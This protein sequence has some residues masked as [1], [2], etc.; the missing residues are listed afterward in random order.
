MFVYLT[1]LYPPPNP[2]LRRFLLLPFRFP[3]RPTEGLLYAS[4]FLSFALTSYLMKRL[5]TSTKKVS[6]GEKKIVFIEIAKLEILKCL[7]PLHK[8]LKGR[9][10]RLNEIKITLDTHIKLY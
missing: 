7:Y 2:T 6:L 3:L 1:R 8:G 9:N 5:F 10:T 4:Q